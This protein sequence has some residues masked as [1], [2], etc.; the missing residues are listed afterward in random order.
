MCPAQ[1]DG[2]RVPV[3]LG[4]RRKMI[5]GKQC[6]LVSEELVEAADGVGADG[7]H[8][9]GAV[10][11]DSDMGVAC[12][13][14]WSLSTYPD[15]EPSAGP[16]RPAKV[17]SAVIANASI[18]C[19]RVRTHEVA[20]EG[21]RSIPDERH[22]PASPIHGV[23]GEAAVAHEP[24][25]DAFDAPAACQDVVFISRSPMECGPK[26]WRGITEVVT[27]HFSEPG[28]LEWLSAHGS[29]PE[30]V[31]ALPLRARIVRDRFGR[32]KAEGAF[33]TA[34]ANA[35]PD[36]GPTPGSRTDSASRLSSPSPAGPPP[37]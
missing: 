2:A 5:T 6:L 15:A 20:R 30:R 13:H 23:S 22:P 7:L 33:R 34:P 28:D 4:A 25:E 19:V 14:R 26:M 32:E 9:P 17:G 1:P 24:A 29:D 11:H 12:V 36:P 27:F 35:R 8:G 37:G 10:E 18:Y 3:G 31:S 21:K 16:D